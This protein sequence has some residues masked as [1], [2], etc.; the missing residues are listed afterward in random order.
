MKH[1][2]A[3]VAT[4][5][6]A[7]AAGAAAAPDTLR[8][9]LYY[10]TT[11]TLTLTQNQFPRDTIPV[12]FTIGVNGWLY[13][14][15]PVCRFAFHAGGISLTTVHARYPYT[16]VDTSRIAF[17]PGT[18]GRYYAPY[19]MDQDNPQLPGPHPPLDSKNQ[20]QVNLRWRGGA[21]STQTR[22]VRQ[23]TTIAVMERAVYDLS[24]RRVNP[25]RATGA[26]IRR[27]PEIHR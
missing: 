12:V 15:E 19:I 8:I 10:D 1:T 21:S 9:I 4:I 18:A 6:A 17:P 24:G 14:P 25:T 23:R 11:I 5:I 2:L 13:V 3:A 16:D 7:L 22:P 20:V 26:P 27:I